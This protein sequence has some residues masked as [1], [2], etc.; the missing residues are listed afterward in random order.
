MAKSKKQK[1]TEAEV[2]RAEYD[3][4]STV[5]KIRRAERA[6]GTSKKQLKRLRKELNSSK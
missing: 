5:E 1:R 4:L 2:R 6:R 3:A